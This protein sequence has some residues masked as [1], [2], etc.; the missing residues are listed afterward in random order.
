MAC[1]DTACFGIEI[2]DDI[3]VH[4]PGVL[5]LGNDTIPNVPDVLE[6]LRELGKKVVFV[7]NNSTKSRVQNAKKFV[8]AHGI[9]V[10]P[11]CPKC[12]YA[13]K[14]DLLNALRDLL[15]TKCSLQINANVMFFYKK[16]A[17]RESSMNV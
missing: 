8:D 15:L 7:T 13:M 16:N 3:S 17:V 2:K 6:R 1:R 12:S 11:V 5:W 4:P 14:C 9:N 10:Q